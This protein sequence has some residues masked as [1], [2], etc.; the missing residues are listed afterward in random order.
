[1]QLY[2]IFPLFNLVIVK[3]KHHC[4]FTFLHCDMLSFFELHEKYII[5]TNA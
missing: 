1:M 5:A 4:N 3:A 2:T